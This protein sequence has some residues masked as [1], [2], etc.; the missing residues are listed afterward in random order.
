[1]NTKNF[2]LK[3]ALAYLISIP[4]IISGFN[5]T[6]FANAGGEQ[7]GNAE[8]GGE[9]VQISTEAELN[10]FARRVN[11][12]ATRLNAILMNDITINNEN[13]WDP[14]GFVTRNDDGEIEKN[15]SYEGNFNGNNK[16]IK[17][18][19]ID[20]KED[21]VG[22]FGVVGEKGTIRDLTIAGSYIKGVNCVGGIAG[23]NLGEIENCKNKNDVIVEGEECIGGNVGLNEGG[24]IENCSNEGKVKGKK[25]IGG[26]VAANFNIGGVCEER[27]DGSVTFTE[28][29]MGI[30]KLCNNK[31]T[32]EGDINE[33]E[34]VGGNVGEN[35]GEV[36]ECNNI[37]SVSGGCHVGG[38]AGTNK[39]TIIRCENE[40]EIAGCDNIGGN[41]GVNAEEESN[42]YYSVSLEEE[43]LK[44]KI[45]DCHN[46]GVVRGLYYNIGGIVGKNCKRGLIKGCYNKEDGQVVIENGEEVNEEEVNRNSVGGIVG[47]NE[48]VIEKCNNEGLVKGKNSVGGIAGENGGVILNC[49]NMNSVTGLSQVGGIVGLNDGRIAGTDDISIVSKCN[50]KGEVTGKSSVGGNIGL[51]IYQAIVSECNN[52]GRV[53]GDKE[54]GENVGC[55]RGS[56]KMT[57][58]GNT[59]EVIRTQ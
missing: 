28:L 48:G 38:N 51:I 2:S 31:G 56:L 49:N 25:C 20:K 24:K 5:M 9:R 21:G 42:N 13:N 27:E 39:G 37:G 17:G 6:I 32:I 35:E 36:N 23:V 22:L 55:T 33:G 58:C 29:H 50:N 57:N 26:N 54:V 52:E 12:G 18:L 44:V 47:E 43:K 41:V 4:V 14:I 53:T 15:N 19:H 34:N 8:I 30:I 11:E 1:M 59:G 40:G 16:T 45:E 3:R 7:N 10:D 46:K